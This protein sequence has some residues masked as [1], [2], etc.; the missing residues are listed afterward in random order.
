[1]LN[2][3][4]SLASGLGFSLDDN[5]IKTFPSGFFSSISN[6]VTLPAGSS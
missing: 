4:R 3:D 2:G 1:L 6:E 5:E